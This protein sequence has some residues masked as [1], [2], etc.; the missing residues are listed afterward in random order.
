L[1]NSSKIIF[2][3]KAETPHKL[4]FEGFPFFLQ[5]LRKRLKK[6]VFEG[7]PLFLRRFHGT[8]RGLHAWVCGKN[9]ISLQLILSVVS[10]YQSFSKIIFVLLLIIMIVFT[11]S[12]LGPGTPGSPAGPGSPVSPGSPAT[13]GDPLS[14]LVI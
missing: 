4:G 8:A 10:F 2:R 9:L 3:W 13:P 6:T 14:E 12:P 1:G 5:Q 11:M 7:F